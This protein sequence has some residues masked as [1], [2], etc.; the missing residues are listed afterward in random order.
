[1]KVIIVG[2]GIGGLTT[3]LALHH[4]GIEAQI[5]ESVGELRALGVG[6]N[7]L[8]HSVRRLDEWGAMAA[9]LDFAIP[10]KEQVYFN[11]FG[12]KICSQ[13]RGLDEGYRWPQLSVH[14]GELQLAL[15]NMVRDRLGPQ[16]V[17]TRHHLQ[18]FEQNSNGSVTAHFSDLQTGER[19]ASATG[20]VL[21]GADGIHSAVRKCLYPDEGPAKWN[22]GLMFR[23]VT[24]SDPFL[25]GQSIVALGGVQT[26]LAYPISKIHLERGR[27][28]TNWVARYYI[29]T[30]NGFEQE[31]WNRR[32]D[33]EKLLA[34]YSGWKTDWLDIPRLIAEADKVYEYPMV[35]RDPLERWTFGRVTLL[36]DAAHPMYPL[37]SNG[38][39]QAILDSYSLSASL[40]DHDDLDEAL[41]AYE[42]DR[43]P[44][45]SRVV[46]ANRSGGPEVVIRITE[47]RAPT[48]FQHIDEVLPKSELDQ[49]LEAYRKAASFDL[50][51]V[52]G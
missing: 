8:P 47:S 15:L 5:F 24:E 19:V 32:A 1:M 51:T 43:R 29:D 41:N 11:K 36:G 34:T 22:G 38:A 20:D 28:L 46:M 48:G 49:I 17:M 9:L 44:K 14:R 39:S 42:Q 31:D 2:A 12:Q 21:V 26:F 23:G 16:S 30:A 18:S 45:T 25:T 50:E 3:A 37:G 10:T 40:A 35:D 6:I 4:R 33:R 13:A 27:S 52:N 7:L